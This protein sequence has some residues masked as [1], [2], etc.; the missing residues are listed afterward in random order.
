MTQTPW[1]GITVRNSM[2]EG[3]TT[4]RP[5][6]SN[7]PDILISG[8]L[9]Y[10]NPS[11]L[12]ELAN[13]G[14][15]YPNKLKIGGVNY[16]YIRGRN[17]TG[18]ELKGK[19]TLYFAEPNILLYPY[20]WERNQLA[21]SQSVKNPDFT[22][23]AGAIGASTD[24][25]RWIPPDVQDHY[26]L[27]A[28]AET[29]GHGNPLAGVS[30]VN[31]LAETLANNANIAQRNVQMI[32]GTQPQQI[33]NAR[34]NQGSEAARMDLSFVFENIPLKSSFR[35]S[36]GTLL[37][38]RALQLENKE[39]TNFDFKQSLINLDFP[40][41]WNS[42]FTVELKLGSQF[43]P[44][45]T[46]SVEI[47]GEIITDSA[48]PLYHLG[49]PADPD[50]KTGAIRMAADGGPVRVVRV[51]SVKGNFYEANPNVKLVIK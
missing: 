30:N 12:T 3:G 14:T 1:P 6:T 35:A 27:I 44:T 4:P 18:A 21:T 9:P 20:L 32:R 7:S 43:P 47:R 31:G 41:N 40:A 8:D 2:S 33:M 50:P 38:G 22:I 26:C 17:Y 36:S 51:G 28:I 16:L 25:F 39:T 11:F 34:Y 37:N 5:A 13:Y 19:W 45:G 49:I 24:A 42:L 29:E 48:H 10:E 23:G 46:P 15:Y